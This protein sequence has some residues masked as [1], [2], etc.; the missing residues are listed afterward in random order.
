M[1][2][3]PNMKYKTLKLLEDNIKKNLDD[4]KIH[5]VFL[6]TIPKT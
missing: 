6:G 4:L 3:K 1:S 5:D 2:N